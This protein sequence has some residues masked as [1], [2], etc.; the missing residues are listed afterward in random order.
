V[1]C[2]AT[3]ARDGSKRFWRG[4]SPTACERS[5]AFS[6]RK[7][8]QDGALAASPG[9]DSTRSRRK[10]RQHSLDHRGEMDAEP[11]RAR[12]IVLV[13]LIINDPIGSEGSVPGETTVGTKHKIK[14]ANR[15]GSCAG[16][17]RPDPVVEQGRAERSSELDRGFAVADWTQGCQSHDHQSSASACR[18]M[19]QHNTH[20]LQS[21][22][23][24]CMR[25][26]AAI[27]G[28]VGQCRTLRDT[29]STGCI[30]PESATRTHCVIRT[31]LT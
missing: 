10:T 12:L 13:C 11:R 15:C 2:T 25:P 30:R 6:S 22:Y 18:I 14:L 29:S 28:S 26:D 24:R 23:L 27:S 31:T 20:H 5:E 1:S 17:V 9:E 3:A 21:N 16:A 19:L 8:R 4:G 7:L